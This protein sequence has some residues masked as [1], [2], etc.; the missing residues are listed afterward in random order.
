MHA[1]FFLKK[2]CALGR[3]RIVAL[4]FF[5]PSPDLAR[6][7]VT[8]ESS[9]PQG[10]LRSDNLRALGG[11][12]RLSDDGEGPAVGT[13]Y[14]SPCVS[15]SIHLSLPLSPVV[16]A[17]VGAGFPGRRRDGLQRWRRRPPQSPCSPSA[18]SCYPARPR[19]RQAAAT[20]GNC[21]FIYLMETYLTKNF[22]QVFCFRF[23]SFCFLFLMEN[24]L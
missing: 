9:A 13:L 12:A 6:L 10:E 8:S 21:F 14:L 1:R 20:V 24:F 7:Q 18:A 11:A 19:I 22:I 16:E 5:F 4:S 3:A 15:F 23:F 2:T 17:P